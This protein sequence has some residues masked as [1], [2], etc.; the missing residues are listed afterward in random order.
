MRRL[1][2]TAQEA[3]RASS[4]VKLPMLERIKH[5]AGPV[6]GIAADQV[7]GEIPY[8]AEQFDRRMMALQQFETT[9]ADRRPRC[10]WPDSATPNAIEQATGLFTVAGTEIHQGGEPRVPVPAISAA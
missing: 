7:A 1:A 4:G 8:R 6:A 5:Q 10:R 3:Q 2:N 9:P